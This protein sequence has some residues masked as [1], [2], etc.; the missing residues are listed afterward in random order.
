VRLDVSIGTV[1]R[2]LHGR[3]R[4]SEETRARVLDA[5][6]A[7]GY[8]PNLAARSLSARTRQT[9]A[10]CLP[11]A[12]EAFYGD[13][14]EGIAAAAEPF[15]QR[16][17]D[18]AWFDHS[19]L[20]TGEL[21]AFGAALA[22]RPAGIVMAPGDPAAAAPLLEEA[23]RRRIPVVC[24]S[25]DAPAAPRLS[26]IAVDPRTS[27]A[28]VGE[29]IGRCL[30]GR[31][32]IALVSGSLATTDHAGKLEGLEAAC[33]SWWPTLRIAHVLEA[34]DDER[35]AR[36][37]M[38]ALLA[39]RAGCDAVYVS[40]ANSLPVLKEI[41]RA[42]RHA[43]RLGA[44]RASRSPLVVTTDLF[45]ALVPYIARGTVAATIHQRPRTQGRLA[46]D[47]L[48]RYLVDRIEPPSSV[49][50]SPHVVMRANLHLFSGPEV[51]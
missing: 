7:L 44:T 31:G 12:L 2:A 23:S 28:L 21:E 42:V 30:N 38:R 36:T 1:D 10:V 17:V 37:T 34:H 33:R 8:R 29:L 48:R 6:A 40:T 51:S 26:S 11:R 43:G 27:G 39:A 19:R 41:D 15:V 13:V 32:T 22:S 35:E 45:P 20:G 50:L 9:I 25:T 3:G 18:L 24:V 49:R 47:T 46:I 5:A 16:G 14:R 4:I